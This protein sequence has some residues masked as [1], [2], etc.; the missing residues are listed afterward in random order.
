MAGRRWQDDVN[1]RSFAKVF[2]KLLCLSAMLL[3][4]PAAVRAQA[5]DTTNTIAATVEALDWK[6]QGA[7]ITFDR[8][9]LDRLLDEHVTYTHSIGLLQT[10]Q[11]LYD[12][13]AEGN[14]SYDSFTNE[15][16]RW[17]VF[18][19]LVVGTGNQTI[20]LT[21]DGNPATS[22]SRFTIVWRLV[23]GAWKCV[24]YQSTPVPNLKEQ[25]TFR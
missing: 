17:R 3:A 18:P 24:A 14:V 6:R 4:L 2:V 21:I 16:V 19:G 7:M 11:Q 25:Q 15:K 10:R 9:T 22:H 23:D 20:N 1:R 5:S 13:L 12:M 8:D